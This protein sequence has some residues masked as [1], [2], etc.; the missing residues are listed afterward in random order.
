MFRI[1]DR[2]SIAIGSGGRDGAASLTIDGRGRSLDGN[3]GGRSLTLVLS[4]GGGAG[5]AIRVGTGPGRR[6][7]PGIRLPGRGVR[8]GGRGSSLTE[9]QAT[10]RRKEPPCVGSGTQSPPNRNTIAAPVTR[11]TIV[12]AIRIQLRFFG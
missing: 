10:A 11:T 8:F 3:R 7:A 5:G 12:A 4:F 1:C 9:G 6:E 2:P